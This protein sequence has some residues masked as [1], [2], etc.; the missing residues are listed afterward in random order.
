M[1]LHPVSTQQQMLQQSL[2]KC[3]LLQIQLQVTQQAAVLP[4][5]LALGL[6]GLETLMMAAAEAAAAHHQGGTTCW[7][8]RDSQSVG[9]K[10]QQFSTVGGLMPLE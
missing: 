10:Q 1:R 2:K 7:S 9:Q 6:A 3:L 8:S 4:A 5:A